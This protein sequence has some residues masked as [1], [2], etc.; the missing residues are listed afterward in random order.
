MFIMNAGITGILPKAVRPVLGTLAS[1]PV[2]NLIKKIKRQFKDLFQER[3]AL[4]QNP[5]SEKDPQ[6]L[7]Q[8]MFR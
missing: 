3:L 6:D 8:M 4:I 1:I 5:K 2:Q 7:I